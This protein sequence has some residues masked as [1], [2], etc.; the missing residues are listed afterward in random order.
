[1]ESYVTSTNLTGSQIN[2]LQMKMDKLPT[3][4]NV[5]FDL[6]IDTYLIEMDKV[7]EQYDELKKLKTLFIIQNIKLNHIK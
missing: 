5:K 7:T 4:D 6:D 2:I 3:Y 1:M